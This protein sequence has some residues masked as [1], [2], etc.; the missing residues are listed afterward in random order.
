[1]SSNNHDPPIVDTL[2]ERASKRCNTS[3]ASDNVTFDIYDYD[4]CKDDDSEKLKSRKDLSWRAKDSHYDWTIY[5]TREDGKDNETDIPPYHV[6]KSFLGAG[7]Y[8]SEHFQALFKSTSNHAEMETC[9][10]R[11]T[12]QSSVAKVFP[13]IL[14]HIYTGKCKVETKSAVA[15]RSLSRYF[16]VR[17]LFNET[18]EFIKA[19]ME[20]SNAHIYLLEAIVYKDE[21]IKTVAKRLCAEMFG[22]LSSSQ[23]CSLSPNL[24]QLILRDKNLNIMSEDLSKK[25]ALYC[26]SCVDTM[27]GSFLASITDSTFM[28]NIHPSEALFFLN[29]C[30]THKSDSLENL[31]DDKTVSLRLRCI[32]ASKQWRVTFDGSVLSGRVKE[33]S[34]IVRS[35]CGYYNLSSLV[36]IELLET[37]LVS[38]SKDML[39]LSVE[40]NRNVQLS[41][42]NK[43][44]RT[45]VARLSSEKTEKLN[46]Y[47][48]PIE[49]SKGGEQGQRW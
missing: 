8:L 9:T 45:S 49:R 29:L 15:L 36:K 3:N 34:T 1:M 48:E 47:T 22:T 21:R 18:A 19:N 32:E 42:S 41:I 23:V 24:L 31:I 28:P 13:D 5:I 43:K 20:I 27:E 16:G 30:I 40:K 37:A 11:I 46:N 26:R 44:L 35:E 10:S 33:E 25:V 12:L 4:T 38:A 2:S 17:T 6:H 7:Q 39:Q 14:D